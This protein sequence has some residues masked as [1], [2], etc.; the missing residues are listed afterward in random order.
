MLTK[1]QILAVEDRKF[2]IVNVPEWGGD[3]RIGTMSASARDEYDRIIMR[4]RDK[5]SDAIDIRAPMVAACL[6][7][8]N[9][10]PLFSPDERVA[11]GRKSG[12]VMVRL[13]NECLKLNGMGED[14]K[15][16]AKGE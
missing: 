6:V 12:P 13:F 5:S 1:G 8:E 3:V 11:L 14:A 10:E 15:E 4:M 2:A 16:Q 9:G 7:D